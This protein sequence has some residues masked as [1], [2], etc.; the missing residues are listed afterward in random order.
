MPNKEMEKL[1]EL[2]KP[3]VE[4]LK[5]NWDPHCAVIITDS[6]IKLVRDEMGCPTRSDD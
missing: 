2:C 1:N 4:Y 3:V 5:R 6:H